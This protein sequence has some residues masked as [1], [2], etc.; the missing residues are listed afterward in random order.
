VSGDTIGRQVWIETWFTRIEG[1]GLSSL[2]FPILELA[3]AFGCLGSQTLLLVQPFVTGII[4]DATF[5]KTVEIL[6]DPEFHQQLTDYVESKENR[7]EQ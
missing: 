1:L 6:E 7:I 3:R 2:V 5:S 4:S